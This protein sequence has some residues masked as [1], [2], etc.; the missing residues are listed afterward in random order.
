MEEISNNNNSPQDNARKKGMDRRSFLKTLGASLVLSPFASVLMKEGAILY[1]KR[2]LV[3]RTLRGEGSVT[4]EAVEK[5]RTFLRDEYGVEVQIGDSW[6]E[7]NSSVE[8]LD[9]E[10]A[11]KALAYLIEEMGK[12]PP[13]F[14]NRNKVQAIRI[15]KDVHVGHPLFDNHPVEGFAKRQL[16]QMTLDF[17]ATEEF[18]RGT[19][20]HE[21]NHILDFWNGG[22][23]SNER[24]EQIHA[25]CT[26][27]PEVRRKAYDENTVTEFERSFINAYG[28][29]SALEER[30][31]F[32]SHM[33][34][35]RLHAKFLGRLS[36]EKSEDSQILRRKYD[37]MKQDFFRWSDGKMNDAY[38]NSLIAR[39]SEG[40]IGDGY[41]FVEYGDF[42]YYDTFKQ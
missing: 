28:A 35:P 1:Q 20:H 19:F 18:F 12:Y 15:G 5:A 32:A 34:I 24:W 37:A 25:G 3:L 41:D 30:A 4:T 16:R 39:A 2:A 26:C 21:L 17:S 13:D 6:A 29:S 10:E 33:M 11:T 27:I 31:E 8:W 42:F 38:W 23:S 36:T 9:S 14:F 7:K 22:P 40:T